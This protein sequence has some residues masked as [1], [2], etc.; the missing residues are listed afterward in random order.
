M[1]SKSAD[2]SSFRRG[3]VDLIRQQNLGKNGAFAQMKGA[4]SVKDIR[5]QD[6]G[7]HQVRRKFD[8]AKLSLDQARKRFL[9][10]QRFAG[11][12][13]HLPVEHAHR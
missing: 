8:P 2:K 3:A 5:S 4:D 6:I 7:R 10:H 1:A 11:V 12:P 9:R 13:V